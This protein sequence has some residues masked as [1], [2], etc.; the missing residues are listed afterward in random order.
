MKIGYA[1]VSTKH[2]RD[3]L[4]Q[5]IALLKNAGCKEIYSEIISG[6]SAKRPELTKLLDKI[7][8]GHT[9]IIVSVDR[10]GR[11][12]KDLIGIISSLKERFIS[13]QSLK[14]QM[15]TGTDTGMLMFNMMGSIAEFERSLINRRIYEGVKR[16]QEQGKYKGR[17]HS[18]D[19][20]IRQEY[21]NMMKD[22]KYAVSYVARMAKVSRQTLY[23]WKMDFEPST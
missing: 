20:T 4:D 7:Q 23:N 6:T 5:Q 21:V 2:Q 1:R 10:L 18:A 16:A 14:E 15:D 19:K 9:L 3:A 12:L 8:T 22:G 17:N 11:S 13:F